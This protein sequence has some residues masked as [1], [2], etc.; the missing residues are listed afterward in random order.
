M[1]VSSER[2]T[3]QE[4]LLDTQNAIQWLFLYIFKFTLTNYEANEMV[5]FFYVTNIL[6]F[7]PQWFL[8]FCHFIFQLRLS[9][10]EK[11]K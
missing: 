7:T 6:N 2:P 11:H 1:Q 3:D 9:D 5:S 8:C 4:D 10:I